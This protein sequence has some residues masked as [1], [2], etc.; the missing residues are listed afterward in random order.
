M[1]PRIA[2]TKD[3]YSA[4]Y[5]ELKRGLLLV[6]LEHIETLKAE[7]LSLDKVMEFELISTYVE[8]GKVF[9]VQPLDEWKE[10]TCKT[11]NDFSQTPCVSCDLAKYLRS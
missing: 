2:E 4:V 11:C 10:S 6:G 5:L 1:T 7:N 9:K 8:T 3:G